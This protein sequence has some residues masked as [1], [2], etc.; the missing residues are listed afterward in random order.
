MW[1]SIETA[2]GAPREVEVK[3]ERLVIGRDPSCDIVIDDEELSRQHAELRT[4]P[5]GRLEI[6]DL[7]S[8][9]G[10]F[11]GGVRIEGPATL[12]GG[13]SLRLGK[14]EMLASREP[15]AAGRTKM[16]SR[17][18]SAVSR[19][20]QRAVQRA[21][22]LAVGAVAIAAIA[23]ILAVSGVFSGDDDGERPLR[24]IIAD[25]R[26]S[27]VLVIAYQEGSR[28]GNG[29]GWVLDAEEGL[30]VTN[31]HVVDAGETFQASTG[32]EEDVRAA[33]VVGVAPC[34]DLALLRLAETEGLETLPLGSQ[35]ELQQGD[36][37]VAL[38]FPGN[39]SPQDE[40]Q[41]TS[42]EVSVVQQTYDIPD[43]PNVQLYPNVIQVT[44][45][46]NPGNSGGPLVNAEGELVG[47]NTLIFRGQQGEVQGQGYAIGVDHAEEVLATLRE[48]TSIGWMGFG[49][50]AGSFGG[51]DVTATVAGTSAD[52]V[53][54]GPGVN[55]T[56][57]GGT[58]V[59]TFRDYCEAVEGTESGDEVEIVGSV[60]GSPTQRGTLTFE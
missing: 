28:T 8:Q 38:G 49:F 60:Q 35:S 15:G 55:L 31:A 58:R 23:V 13:E 42:G 52:E 4:L 40:L 47:V 32:D 10:T 20:L 34:D 54:I 53:G 43:D 27:T 22:L 6:R 5:D 14:T 57:I 39:A 2:S 51:L 30:V 56:S 33:E 21:T 45:A 36:T 26:P 3:G 7:D 12:E 9:N 41:S 1:L 46:I 16:A 24:E 19:G 44:A 48:G 59:N 25:A 50:L 29:T 11:V 18:A 37:V 17:T